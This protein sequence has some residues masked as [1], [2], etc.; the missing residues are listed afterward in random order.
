MVYYITDGINY[1]AS[2]NASNPKMTK[3]R[4]EALKYPTEARA[5]K[6]FS[7]FLAHF[8]K[9]TQE[10]WK[11]KAEDEEWAEPVML[12]LKCER[13]YLSSDLSLTTTKERAQKWEESKA[14]N[15]LQNQCSTHP[16]LK[17]YHWELIPAEEEPVPDDFEG[18]EESAVLEFAFHGTDPDAYSVSAPCMEGLLSFT[19]NSMS[20]DNS[21]DLARAVY[22]FYNG[23]ESRKEQ[24]TEERRKAD[25]QIRVIE[26]AIE[27]N[28]YDSQ[29]EHTLIQ[30][31]RSIRQRR[32]K[33][34]DELTVINAFLRYITP[35]QVQKMHIDTQTLEGR[36][37]SPKAFPELFRDSE[38]V[39]IPSP[40][41]VDSNENMSK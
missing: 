9:K 17:I 10:K 38:N 1:L 5:F 29:T 40:S 30:L 35:D 3:N 36:Y 37:Y 25:I 27:F 33:C 34:K 28:E 16:L 2:E 41:G 12:Y 32:R 13:G 14:S 39:F 18:W 7:A 15:V 23:I 19:D 8:S 11:I 26:H 6:A 20:V 31:I 24:L 21:L 22:Q 4:E